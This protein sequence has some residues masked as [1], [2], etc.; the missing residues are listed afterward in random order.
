MMTDGETSRYEFFV[1]IDPCSASNLQ[2]PFL[3]VIDV[4]QH[5]GHWSKGLFSSSSDNA[6]TLSTQKF[7]D[8]AAPDIIDTI[9]IK[10]GKK[11]LN[12]YL[13]N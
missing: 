2:R 1:Q 13:Q 7:F 5:D 3:H 10:K 6:D 11:N 12:I 9:S 8:N 4:E